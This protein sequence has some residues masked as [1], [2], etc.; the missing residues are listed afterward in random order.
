MRARSTAWEA[1]VRS[2][3]RKSACLSTPA[4]LAVSGK[5]SPRAAA[6]SNSAPSSSTAIATP[7]V[8]AGERGAVTMRWPIASCSARSVSR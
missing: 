5:A 3:P 4:S 6:P 8:H 1:G 7:W 2:M